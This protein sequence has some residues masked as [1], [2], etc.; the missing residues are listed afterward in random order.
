MEDGENWGIHRVS[1]L[2]SEY[3]SLLGKGENPSF[4][5]EDFMDIAEYYLRAYKYSEANEALRIADR[6]YPDNIDIKI[7]QAYSLKDE[8]RWDLALKVI[9]NLPKSCDNRD[10]RMFNIEYMLSL[11][12]LDEAEEQFGEIIRETASEEAGELYLSFAEMLFNYG[13]ANRAEYWINHYHPSEMGGFVEADSQRKQYYELRAD[14]CYQL[15][16]YDEAIDFANKLID[17]DP[18]DDISWTQLAE[19]YTAKQDYP[20]AMDSVEY[21]I[22]INPKSPKSLRQ[23]LLILTAI[24]LEPNLQIVSNTYAEYRKYYDDDYYVHIAVGNYFARYGRH[25][26]SLGCYRLALH[27]CPSQ[28]VERVEVFRKIASAY[29]NMEYYNEAL[30]AMLSSMGPG[31]RVVEFYIQIAEC[32]RIKGNHHS[33]SDILLGF[34]REY[35]PT[36]DDIKTIMSYYYKYAVYEG[37]EAAWRELRNIYKKDDSDFDKILDYATRR[38]S[39]DKS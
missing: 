29:A 20:N 6:R 1:K 9:K 34:L 17:I 27:K 30:E 21:A 10:A 18:Y 31:D 36:Q 23:K 4:S 24:D 13:Y 37:A 32:C 12:S 5:A 3:E 22:S 14:I 33:C 2:V 26:D 16:H 38:L 19:I 28:G 8:G 35:K 25:N 11:S 15:H 7:M 39:L